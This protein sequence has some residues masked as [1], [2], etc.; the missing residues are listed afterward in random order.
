MVNEVRI[1]LKVVERSSRGDGVRVFGFDNM[2][3]IG[4]WGRVIL[5]E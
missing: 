4:S 3:V 5:V 1:M 2:E